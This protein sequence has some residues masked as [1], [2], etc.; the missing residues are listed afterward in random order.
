MPFVFK[1]DTTLFSTINNAIL[2][3]YLAQIVL[4][5]T[6]I[7]DPTIPFQEKIL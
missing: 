4:L 3:E 1:V 5:L 7:L 6:E 2:S